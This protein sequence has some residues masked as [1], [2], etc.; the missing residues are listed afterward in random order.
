MYL[1][2][3]GKDVQS[4]Y[5]YLLKNM[6]STIIENNKRYTLKEFYDYQ[7]E[8]YRTGK[9]KLPPNMYQTADDY[10][11]EAGTADELFDFMA[12]RRQHHLL[13]TDGDNSLQTLN[14][15]RTCLKQPNVVAEFGTMPRGVGMENAMI[16]TKS[17]Y[18]SHAYSVTGYNQATDNVQYIN[19]WN[20]AF[21]F[22]MPL[23]DLAKSINHISFS[24]RV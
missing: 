19:P 6:N 2:Y 10:Y 11:K 9:S 24:R 20:S 21:V 18:S 8:L 7:V 5:N 14:D 13:V 3:T 4:E 22:E 17:L 15:M 16:P 1:K 23:Q 12:D